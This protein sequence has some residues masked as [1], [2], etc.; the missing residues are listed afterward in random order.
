[1]DLIKNIPAN[2]EESMKTFVSMLGQFF[3]FGYNL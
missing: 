3:D 1:M 2:F